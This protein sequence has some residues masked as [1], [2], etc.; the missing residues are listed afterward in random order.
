MPIPAT[1]DSADP[2]EPQAA[3][4]GLQTAV[5]VFGMTLFTMVVGT[6]LYG[7]QEQSE[8]AFRLLPW[9]RPRPEP[10]S[11]EHDARSQRL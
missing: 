10:T 3:G 7:T 8:R 4:S 2:T 1:T 5:V 6:A 9:L 11:D